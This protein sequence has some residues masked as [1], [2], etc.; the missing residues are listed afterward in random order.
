MR[1][2]AEL[3]STS[4]RNSINTSRTGPSVRGPSPRRMQ[5]VLR[6]MLKRSGHTAIVLGY[7]GA[8]MSVGALHQLSPTRRAPPRMS[9]LTPVHHVASRS[10]GWKFVR[11]EKAIVISSRCRL[12]R[13]WSSSCI[14]TASGGRAIAPARRGRPLC[15]DRHSSRANNV[16]R[17]RVEWWVL[18]Y[19]G[20][21]SATGR[22]QGCC[23]E[24]Q[25]TVARIICSRH[26]RVCLYH[27]PPHAMRTHSK[28]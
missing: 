23:D 18:A 10:A 14:A 20:Q 7:A 25:V 11:A 16:S 5:R 13:Q 28:W 19:I 6:V 26:A 15:L 9:S 2:L 27:P 4:P 21:T 8:L 3:E 24:I 12:H 1:T 22:G 17:R